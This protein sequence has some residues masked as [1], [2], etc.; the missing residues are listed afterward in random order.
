MGLTD[1]LRSLFIPPMYP[2]VDNFWPYA[3]TNGRVYPLTFNQTLT[4]NRDEPDGTYTGLV[5]WAYQ[6]DPVVFA[7]MNRRAELFSEAR[8]QW[9]QVRNGRP[10]DLF[11]TGELGILE[12]P[13]PNGTTGDL[14]SRMI[15]D[16]DLCG[17]AFIARIGDRLVRLR[18]D[19]VTIVMG[20]DQDPDVKPW[21]L[22]ATVMGY[23]YQPG[24]PAQGRRITT[25]DGRQVAHFAPIPDPLH[26][27]R[28]MSWLTPV[29][30]EI[31]AD[32]AATEH[33]ARF[34]ENGA[35][36][37]MVVSFDP[38]V[39]KTAFDAYREAFREGH[40]GAA[41]AYKTMFLGGGAK[42]DV[43]GKDFAQLDFKITQGA[44]ETRIAAAAG[45]PPAVAGLSEGLQGSS[46]NSGNFTA[47]IR[48]F[49]DMTIRPLWRNACAS[50]EPLV[51]VPGGAELWYDDRDIAALKDDIL[52]FAEIQGKQATAIRTYVDAGFDP[53]SAVDAVNSG[54]LG[55]LEHTG[56]YSVQLQPPQPEGP[57]PAPEPA[58]SPQGMPMEDMPEEPAVP[59]GGSKE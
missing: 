2:P 29:L 50:L 24:G 8:F 5:A 16:V 27:Y 36:P 31:G 30:R 38:S 35:T 9:R 23:G 15:Q 11:G 14:L 57:P 28:G 13:W 17:N 59:S 51:R 39:S 52:D 37:S 32:R 1:R 42:V 48:L 21:D 45:V 44:G 41:N 34:F 10:G 25:L 12:D 19:W 4:G 3:L 18:P 40:E 33:K 46:L 55:R 56:L 6:S 58:A 22:Q 47:A 20:S 54:D 49:A 26:P 53:A 7:C 43:V